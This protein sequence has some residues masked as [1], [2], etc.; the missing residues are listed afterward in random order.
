MFGVR[1]TRDKSTPEAISFR[2]MRRAIGILGMALPVILFV[3]SVL[4]TGGHFLLDSI[5]SYYHTN[6][7]DIFVG[8]LCA[9]SLFLFAYHGYNKVDFIAFKIAGA[10]ALGVAFF[11]AFI[12]SP[13]NPW[14]HIMPNVS[15]L[16][17]TVHY[18]S[19]AIFF[20][21]LA[22]VCLFLF[23]RSG[24]GVRFAS[25][26][27]RKIIRNG[28]Y[29]ACGSIMLLCILSML[30]FNFIPDG[31]PFLSLDPVFWV[32]TIAL[33]AFATSWLVKREVVFKDKIT[34]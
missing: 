30:V 18:I 20:T 12:K 16:T 4:L 24:Q 33:F 7:R 9:V 3:W 22:F 27:K 6:V 13:E 2:T 29:I 32:E 31:S 23:T 21:T 19:A 8:T 34:G 26:S 11:P 25:L 10:S 15:G 14:V 5:S 17:N 28:I 1:F